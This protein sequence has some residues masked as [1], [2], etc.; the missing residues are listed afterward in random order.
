MSKKYLAMFAILMFLSTSCQTTPG[1]VS[2]KVRDA[3]GNAVSNAKIEVDGKNINTT[4]DSSGNY[5]IDLAIGHYTL[6]CSKT[7]YQIT[8]AD[9]DI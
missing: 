1:N 9:I 3:S 5:S 4:T 6:T 8:S 2:G 7:S